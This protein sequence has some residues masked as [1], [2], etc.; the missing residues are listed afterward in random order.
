MRIVNGNRGKTPWNQTAC[1][2]RCVEVGI[3][4][5]NHAGTVRH[6]CLR[7]GGLSL[8]GLTGQDSTEN[9]YGFYGIQWVYAGGRTTHRKGDPVVLSTT[10]TGFYIAS[11]FPRSGSSP[12]GPTNL[13]GV[14]NCFSVV[15]RG[16]L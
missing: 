9:R 12:G 2:L 3:V 7:V 10:S 6:H 14:K 1:F 11:F 13:N 16:S 15:L 8:G 5:G 4:S